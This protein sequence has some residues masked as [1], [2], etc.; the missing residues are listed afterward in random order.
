MIS[1]Y[2]HVLKVDGAYGDKRAYDPRSWG[3]PAE[4]AMAAARRSSEVFARRSL[5]INGKRNSSTNRP[6]IKARNTVVPGLASVWA[7]IA[8]YRAPNPRSARAIAASRAF[9]QL[10]GPVRHTSGHGQAQPRAAEG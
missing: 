6:A 3:K 10:V 4:N 8:I 2:D 1:K 9:H 7:F 5:R